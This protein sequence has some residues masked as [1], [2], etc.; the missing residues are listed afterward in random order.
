MFVPKITT[1]TQ[2]V[3]T[4]HV[5]NVIVA[6]MSTWEEL[7]IAICKLEDVCSVCTKQPVIIVNIAEMDSL[8]VPLSIIVASVIVMCLVQMVNYNIATD[9]AGNV[10]V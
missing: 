7:V 5:S 1:A 9:T 3:L 2:R 8:G 4:E 10:R 6:T